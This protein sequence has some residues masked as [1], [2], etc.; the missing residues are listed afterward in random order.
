MV[1]AKA[2]V[3][4]KTSS[5]RR[6]STIP[7]SFSAL[8]ISW[9]RRTNLLSRNPEAPNSTAALLVDC[10]GGGDSLILLEING[11]GVAS[12]SDRPVFTCTK[13]AANMC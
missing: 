9:R 1:L 13:V 7:E 4:N 12:R 2:S 6:H 3:E 5:P 10:G 11:S 8:S